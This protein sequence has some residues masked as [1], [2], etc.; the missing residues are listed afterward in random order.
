MRTPSRERSSY[1]TSILRESYQSITRNALISTAAAFSIIAAL[2]ILG[3]FIVF[4]ANVNTMTKA[5]EESLDIQI[6]LKD[7]V[8]QEQKDALEQELRE[9]PDVANVEFESKAQALE[10]FSG[11]LSEYSDILSEYDSEN[12][13][14]PESFIVQAVSADRLSAI[15]DMASEYSDE[16]EYVRYQ[17][18]FISSL[19]R[20]TSFVNLFSVVLMVIMSLI[21]LFLIYNTIRLTV[22]NRQREIEIMKYIGATDNFIQLPFVLEGI[23]IGLIS[24]LLSA[25]LVCMVYYYFIGY[26]NGSMLVRFQG[27]LVAPGQVLAIIVVSFIA[28]GL[29]IGSVGA[30]IA[31]RKYLDV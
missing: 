12:N 22:V 26:L 30:A 3:I 17:E 27:S 5:A 16:V 31:T 11:S 7:G 13:P 14:L 9:N 24:A 1:F 10:N 21:A 4:T 6:F 15:R 8:T 20:F 19:T 25:M 23:F 29:I 2:L 18:S 28:Y